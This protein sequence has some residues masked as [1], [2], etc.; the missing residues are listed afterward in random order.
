MREYL[1][2][3]TTRLGLSTAI[4]FNSRVTALRWDEEE[5]FWEVTVE[6]RP[7]VRNILTLNNRGRRNNYG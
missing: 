3:F 6:D 5:Q 4:Q 1:E 7:R 2:H